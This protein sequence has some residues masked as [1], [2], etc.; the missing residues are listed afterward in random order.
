MVR[1]VGLAAAG[2]LVAFGVTALLLAVTFGNLSGL[3]S[4]FAVRKTMSFRVA[5]AGLLVGAALYLIAARHTGGL[6]TWLN[7]GRFL[8]LTGLAGWLAFTGMLFA[9]QDRLVF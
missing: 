6:R 1:K 2:L 3:S 5:T 4:G 7:F 8:L 9:F